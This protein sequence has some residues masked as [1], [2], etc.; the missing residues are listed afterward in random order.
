M[1]NQEVLFATEDMYDMEEAAAEEVQTEKYLLF[2]SDGLLFGVTAADVM[3]IITN[4]TI[5]SLPLMPEYIRGII[6]LRGQIIPIV[7]IRILLGQPIKE[8]TCIIILNSGGT[9]LGILVDA[10]EKMVDIETQSIL[11]TPAQNR[12]DLVSGICSLEGGQT[13]LVFDCDQVL[14]HV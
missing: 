9:Q 1:Q 3:E 12:K 13:M 7:D 8:D 5:T 14:N 2:L 11:T 10:V 4:H 6:N